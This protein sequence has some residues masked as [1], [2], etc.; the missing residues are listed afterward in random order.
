MVETKENKN[1]MNTMNGTV[2]GAGGQPGIRERKYDPILDDPISS[3]ES[4][5]EEES[6]ESSDEALEIEFPRNNAQELMTFLHREIT[7]LSNMDD[8]QK[9]KFALLKLYQIFVLVISTFKRVLVM[10]I[11]AKTEYCSY[12]G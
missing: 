6:G 11:S 4:G 8:P 2:Q 9:R 5:S 12:F 1:S 10:S 7:N 3:N